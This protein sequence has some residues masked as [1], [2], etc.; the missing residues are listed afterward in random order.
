MAKKAATKATKKAAA[1]TD[2]VHIKSPFAEQVY[3]QLQSIKHTEGGVPDYRR[4]LADSY[5]EV[6]S[7]LTTIEQVL[8]VLWKYPKYRQILSVDDAA[9]KL[10]RLMGY[11]PAFF[12]ER[13]DLSVERWVL[14]LARLSDDDLPLSTRNSLEG[15]S[16]LNTENACT[17]DYC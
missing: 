8:F 5:Q 10:M 9:V 16:S 2:T 3:A 14:L 15:Q 12:H 1:K 17:Y 4:G 7:A 13:R 6:W 11:G